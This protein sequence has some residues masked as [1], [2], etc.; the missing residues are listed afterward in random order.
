[1]TALFFGVVAWFS[2]P[3]PHCDVSCYFSAEDSPF[4]YLYRNWLLPSAYSAQ[5]SIAGTPRGVPYS[6]VWD[7]QLWTLFYEF[8]CYLLLVALALLGLV[9]RRFFTLVVASCVW[10]TVLVITITPSLDD[11]FN[12]LEQT[13]SVIMNLLKFASIF[14]VGALIYLYREKIPDSGWL[15]LACAAL[16]VACLLVPTQGR[17]P[18]DWFTASDLLIPL[19]AYPVLWL[20]IHLPFQKVGSKNDYSYGMY[21]YAYPVTQLLAIAGVQN[22]GYV[23]FTL[24][25]VLATAPLAAAS[26]WLVEKQALSLKKVDAAQLVRGLPGRRAKRSYPTGD[27]GKAVQ[28]DSVSDPPKDS[29]HVAAPAEQ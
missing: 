4:G 23:P 11:Q 16:F 12:S 7:G 26:W 24:L 15:A 21:I 18:A 17:Y 10:L 22:W 9:R 1:M 5:F 13:Q 6:L 19:V 20:G 28:P 25:T 14:L 29:A 27:S 3:V 2:H 8:L